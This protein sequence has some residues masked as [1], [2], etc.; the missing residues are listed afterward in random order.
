MASGI[1]SQSQNFTLHIP[2]AFHL[3]L[4]KSERSGKLF[5]FSLNVPELV[6]VSV[7]LSCGCWRWS[8]RGK[9]VSSSS[10]AYK[11][12]SDVSRQ[13]SC[14]CCGFISFYYTL[15]VSGDVRVHRCRESVARRAFPQP[16]S[17]HIPHRIRD[18]ALRHVCDRARGRAVV[19]QTHWERNKR[20][21]IATVRRIYGLVGCAY[22]C[23][24]KSVQGEFL[25]F[26]TIIPFFVGH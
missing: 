15:L 9:P 11:A 14:T 21:E 16:V 22:A 2:P 4:R 19:R 10:S 23:V 18:R 8:C 26:C 17:G 24:W 20:E 25:S 7:S 13:L 5:G 12:R 3:R 1:W 6:S